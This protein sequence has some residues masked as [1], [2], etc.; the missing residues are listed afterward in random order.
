MFNVYLNGMNIK[1][2]EGLKT[3]VHGNDEIIILSWVSG[4]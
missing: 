4:G 2:R 3:E 1:N